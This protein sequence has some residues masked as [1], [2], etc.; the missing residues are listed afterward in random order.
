MRPRSGTGHSTRPA[1]SSSRPSS[2][3][4]WSPC[5]AA[6]SAR[7][8][9]IR[10]RRSAAS[11]MTWRARRV[12]CQVASEVTRTGPGLWKR[13]PSVRSAATRP[14]A[15]SVSSARAKG[16][17]WPSRR[18]RMRRSGADPE[19]RA[20]A[21]AHGFG[22]GE[23]ADEGGDGGGDQ[24]GGG[25]GGGLLF[26]DPEVALRRVS[27]S[28]VAACLRRKP[29]KAASG[30]VVR[31]GRVRWPIERGARRR[32]WRRARGGG[33]RRRS[34]RRGPA[35]RGSGSGRRALSGLR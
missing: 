34:G 14:W 6:R 16:T 23:A 22:P 21:P 9:W 18:Q 19:Q 7:P 28:L 10:V 13:W 11:G 20:G 1:T 2:G 5:P 17:V 26:E 8:F 24:G 15:W 31:R 29:A 4:M 25:C 27:C 12:V 30:A 35:G 3:T 33:G 32:W